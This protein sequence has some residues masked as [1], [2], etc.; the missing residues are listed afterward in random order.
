LAARLDLRPT[1]RRGQTLLHDANTVRRIVAAA[2]VGPQDVV[3]EVGPGLGSLTL[4]LLEAGAQVI[5]VEIEHVLAEA[6][7]QTVAEHAPDASARLTVLEADAL[8]VT[9][10]PAAPNALVA[11]LPYN[12]S[13]PVLLHLLAR[14]DSIQRG[15]V[16]VQAEVA[17]RLVAAPGSKTYG[18]PSAKLAWY[19][20]S[21]RVGSV[22]A[23]VFWPVPNVE[24]GL[25]EFTSPGH[26][27]VGR[28][29]PSEA[30][31]LRTQSGTSRSNR[32]ACDTTSTIRDGWD[33]ASLESMRFHVLPSVLLCALLAACGSVPEASVSQTPTVEL[34]FTRPGVAKTMVDR[35]VAE[36]GSR[37]VI[38]VEI[39][40]D[41][42]SVSVLNDGQ[43]ETW[44]YREGEI[45]KVPSDLSYVDQ[46]VFDV[47]EFNIS[48]VGELFA[49]AAKVAASDENQLLQIVDYSGGQVMMSVATNP[50]SRTVFFDAD[51]TLL[52]ELDF[53][54]LSGLQ[55][56]L[57][58]VIASLTAVYSVVI[59]PAK[60]VLVDYP[61][62]TFGTIARRQRAAT[63][64]VTTSS[65]EADTD[66]TPFNPKSVSVTV[67]RQ[68]ITKLTVSRD[69]TDDA[70][71]T[72]T[73]EQRED[74]VAPLMHFDVDGN[75]FTTTLKGAP[76]GG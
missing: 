1:K 15:L 61:G 8:K 43:A 14:F 28:R 29:M 65:R 68:V 57:A 44:A 35:I 48:D 16:M 46:G 42:V 34:D 4:G 72:V 69:V 59:D 27:G 49:A 3:L 75:Q 37:E 51:G 50:E 55:Q 38:M 63:V 17:D 74:E 21:R 32:T 18:A 33:A 19:A 12:V 47:D 39:H 6:L 26:P 7:P 60:Q 11:N 2:G 71:W 23:S 73:I 54:T 40:S 13:V 53:E 56:G 9:E 24:S 30:R 41:Q 67:I 22:P 58:E 36:A 20:T 10:L 52:E 45:A 64:P 70:G 66:L 5:A 31:D 25:V 62:E 76:M